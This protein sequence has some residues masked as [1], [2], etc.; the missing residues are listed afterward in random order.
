MTEKVRPTDDRRASRQASK[1][2]SSQTAVKITRK[3]IPAK[4]LS[5]Y[6]QSGPAETQLPVLRLED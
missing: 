5:F 2:H 4:T 3:Q 6:L 1:T